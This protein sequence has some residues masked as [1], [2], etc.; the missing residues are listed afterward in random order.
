M[1]KKFFEKFN[2]EE[3]EAK[4]E[5]I[6][7]LILIVSLIVIFFKFMIGEEYYMYLDS[8]LDIVNQYYPYYV[9]EILNIKEGKFSFWNFDYGFGTSIFNV[10]A[11]AMDIFGIALVVI[12]LIV[13]VS[14]I[15]YL[16]VWMQIAK[17]IVIY[18]LS[19]KFLSYFIKDKTANCLSAYL[20]TFS[21]YFFLWG[22]HFFLG[23]ACVYL[24]VFLIA[25]EH[26]I[27]N[28][29]NS[30]LVLSLLVAALLVFSYY[31]GYMILIV[32]GLYFIFRYFS[33]HEKWEVKGT[34]ISFSKCLYSVV[35]G[36]LLSSIIFIPSCY[37]LLTTS[38]RLDSGEGSIGVRIV[39]AFCESFQPE[40]LTAV[41]TRL[42]S[43]NILFTP[44]NP[45]YY[46]EPQFF[47]TAFIFFFII[48]WII[49]ECKSAKTKKEYL[50]LFIKILALYLLIFNE[51][52]GLV[53]N[54]FAYPIYRYTYVALPFLGIIIGTVWERV[55]KEKKISLIG[56]V[57]SAVVT[58]LMVLYCK[59]RIVVEEVAIVQ[60][61]LI[62]SIVGFIVLFLAK[63]SKKWNQFFVS[64]FLVVVIASNCFDNYITTNHR[65][66]LPKDEYTLVWDKN[67]LADDTGIAI[68]WLKENDKTFYRVE[69]DYANFSFLGDS[70]IER[71]STTL[72]YNSTMNYGMLDF[73]RYIYPNADAYDSIKLFKLE[74][75]SDLQAITL[76]NSKYIL[77]REPIED[78]ASLKEVTRVGGTYVYKNTNTEQIAKFYHQTITS[79]E[80]L[81][82]SDNVQSKILYDTVIVDEKIKALDT[83]ATA[84]VGEFYLEKPTYLTGSIEATGKGILMIAVPYEEGWK[85]FVDGKEEEQY[86]V[87]FGLIG[88]EVEAG[89]HQIELKYEV[90][91]MGI[92]AVC[93]MIGIIGL[94]GLYF[95]EK[96][97]EKSKHFE[98]SDNFD[99]YEKH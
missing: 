53:F 28:S 7:W 4:I 86:P 64:V 21:G 56:L 92:G 95:W 65:L 85:V 87:D 40:F 78:F 61:V 31:I 6:F 15:H 36:V 76:A 54:A 41:G 79:K 24:L 68:S 57:S 30:Y 1:K 27:Q 51:I 97:S 45:N 71:V 62:F 89:N 96:K 22:Q 81:K 46:E 44:S 25:I 32:G 19:K 13:G 99:N 5:I 60:K 63:Y 47:C 94:I 3:K 14:K 75:E 69:K 35:V 34:V 9:N 82:L 12:G 67:K 73:Y 91:K 52:S 55:V 29:K 8:G 66:I 74:N 98:T 80:Y 49:Y 39:Q 90:P 23:T 26:V 72:W 58:I 50:F 42:I 88:I 33:T 2:T 38:S 16:L 83:N 93:S 10:N 48:E 84:K 20:C 43:N 37:H 70:F 59:N 77:S 11:W 18:L 17:I